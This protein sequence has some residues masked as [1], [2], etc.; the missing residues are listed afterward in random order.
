MKI[1][2]KRVGTLIKKS[3]K[4]KGFKTQADLAEALGTE[5]VTVGRWEAGIH[6]P[7]E[8]HLENLYKLLKI[9]ETDLFGPSLEKPKTL[10]ELSAIIE[11]QEKELKELKDFLSLIPKDIAQKIEELDLDDWNSLRAL[12]NWPTKRK[13]KKVL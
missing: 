4:E 9:S 11:R 10:K 3:R 7:S 13:G 2:K 8:E 5:Q 6:L 1:L 12:K